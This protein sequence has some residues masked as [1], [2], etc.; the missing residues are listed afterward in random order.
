MKLVTKNFTYFDIILFSYNCGIN[1]YYN[2]NKKAVTN[3]NQL[4]Y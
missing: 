2:E 4:N 3:L 1:K